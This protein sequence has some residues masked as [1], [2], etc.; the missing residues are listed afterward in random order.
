MLTSKRQHIILSYRI[1]FFL[2][3]HIHFVSLE[4]KRLICF[5]SCLPMANYT[6]HLS[7]HIPKYE[8]RI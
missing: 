8:V 5:S 2:D 6:K 1:T 3:D 4:T 7:I